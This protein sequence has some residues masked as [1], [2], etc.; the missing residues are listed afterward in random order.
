MNFTGIF[1]MWLLNQMPFTKCMDSSTFGAIQSLTT[2][3]MKG[4][5]QRL[6]VVSSILLWYLDC[7]LDCTSISE[8]LEWKKFDLRFLEKFASSQGNKK[9][10]IDKRKKK[11]K[12]L[13]GSG[14]P[15][16]TQTPTNIENPKQD[17]NVKLL[18]FKILL[19]MLFTR[20]ILLELL[21]VGRIMLLSHYRILEGKDLCRNRPK[22]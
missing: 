14:I 9:E 18:S 8:R 12:D 7:P 20:K 22:L 5:C 13:Q 6:G 3:C 16:T 21:R 17:V 4:T 1:Y 2:L 11:N 10:D 19:T 15:W